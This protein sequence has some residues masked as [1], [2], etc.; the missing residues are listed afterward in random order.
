MKSRMFFTVYGAANLGLVLYGV[1]A[2]IMPSVLLE[3]FSLY[4][5]QF[6]TD[7]AGAAAYLAALFRLLGYLN[8]IPGLF[9]LLFL[10]RLAI[11]REAWVRRSVIVLTVLTYLGP[12]VFDNTVGRIG[13]FEFVEHVLFGAVILMGV[14]MWKNQDVSR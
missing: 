11:N 5:F 8:L 4:V 6:P 13:V 9:G 3:P 2:L 1:L 10:R 7:A 14:I 12:I